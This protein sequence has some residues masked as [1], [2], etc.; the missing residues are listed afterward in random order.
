MKNTVRKK[1]YSIAI[2]IAFHIAVSL[3]VDWVE[4]AADKMT[5]ISSR[6]FKACAFDFELFDNFL[7]TL[8]SNPG[9]GAI[10]SEM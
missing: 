9:S 1:E 5:T 10:N 8:T 6:T 4:M 2:S 7:M 3:P